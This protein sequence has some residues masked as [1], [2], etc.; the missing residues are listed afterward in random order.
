MKKICSSLIAVAVL[1][2]V[3]QT[4]WVAAGVPALHSWSQKVATKRFTVLKAFGD[5]AVLDKETGLV[6]EQS[7]SASVFNW[8][9]AQT[10]C[11]QKTVGNRKGWRMPTI[12]E[13]ASL[14][15]GDPANTTNPRLPPGHPFLNVQSLSTFY[16]SATTTTFADTNPND[17]TNAAWVVIFSNGA[18]Q[19][20]GK[21]DSTVHVWCVR[22]GQGVDPQ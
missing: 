12:E 15:D 17:A 7:P 11:N 6:W 18:L 2:M 10:S 8:F 5:A 20:D 14:V 13:L 21:S 16:W 19:K 22:G 1:V 3:V 4:G 9:G